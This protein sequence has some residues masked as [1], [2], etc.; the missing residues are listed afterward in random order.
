MQISAPASQRRIF[1]NNLW[2]I[3]HVIINVVRE[4]DIN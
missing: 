4:V 2:N 3:R 1:H